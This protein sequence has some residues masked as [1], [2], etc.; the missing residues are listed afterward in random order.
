MS[1]EFDGKTVTFSCE[2]G[3]QMK[4]PVE[5]V[6]A[7]GF[8]RACGHRIIV[9]APPSRPKRG[10]SIEPPEYY[11][12]PYH[13]RDLEG[14]YT[15]ADLITHPEEQSG[16]MPPPEID[17]HL[18][19]ERFE[20]KKSLFD[21][22]KEILRYPV[23]NKQAT[24]IFLSGAILFSPLIW[25]FVKILGFIPIFGCL[26]QI[27]AIIS[28]PFIL[29]M[30]FSYLMLIIE[31]SAEGKMH[32]PD[33]PVFTSFGDNF[34]DLLKF[35]A[36]SAIAFSP[37]LVYSASINIEIFGQM[38]EARARGE[39]PGEE[40]F[41]IA[42]GGM[43]MQMLLYVMAS[44]YM[45]MVLLTLVVTKKFSKAVNPVFIFRSISAI[46]REYL[47]AMGIIFILLR[48][49]LTIFTILKDLLAVDWFSSLL[50][51]FAEPIVTFYA[52]VVTMH[53]IGLLYYRNG[54][55]LQW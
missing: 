41:S 14:D 55:R 12:S 16:E 31:K 5:Q 35:L 27:F 1:L 8:C 33:L 24:Q 36:V 34:Q 4:V 30:Y 54:R 11:S 13:R 18:L 44:F 46:W 49:A 52:V 25:E 7:K 2:C 53:V 21:L 39:V 26:V 37:F 51:Y 32:I 40:F 50:A 45:P 22:R 47:V 6:G 19:D 10:A 20:E 3:Q 29:V 43:G 48:L 17:E 23:A 42:S 28:I 15:E 38:M 9:P